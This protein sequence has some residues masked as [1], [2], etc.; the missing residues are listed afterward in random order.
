MTNKKQ[1]RMTVAEYITTMIEASGRQQA[2][3]ARDVGFDKPNVI[4]MIK[5]GKTKLPLN[6]IGKMAMA[7]GV[8]AVHLFRLTMNEY[9]HETWEVIEDIFGGEVL[10][11]N[12]KAILKAVRSAGVGTQ[13]LTGE[14]VRDIARYISVQIPNV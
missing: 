13:K 4:T 1:I 8:D 9:H 7:L 6:K 14:Q 2:E 3:I 11:E 10:T 5:Q 12:E